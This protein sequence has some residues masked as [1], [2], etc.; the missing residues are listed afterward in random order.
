M[1]EERRRVVSEYTETP[2]GQA[3]Y[4]EVVELLLKLFSSE[5]SVPGEREGRRAGGRPRGSSK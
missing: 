1:S 5:R 2:E 4:Q 3:M